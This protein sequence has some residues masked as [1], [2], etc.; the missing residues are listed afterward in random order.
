MVSHIC[1]HRDS[2]RSLIN[3]ESKDY[4]RFLLPYCLLAGRLH[5]T[6]QIPPQTFLAIFCNPTSFIPIIVLS[7]FALR[8]HAPT[9]PSTPLKKTPAISKTK[10][11]RGPTNPLHYTSLTDTTY[12]FIQAKKR[13]TGNSKAMYPSLGKLP[14]LLLWKLLPAR[15]TSIEKEKMR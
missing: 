1:T 9:L 10:S 6:P 3:I 14:G 11:G 5:T 15:S 8:K 7:F 12:M 13:A 2:L 4:Y